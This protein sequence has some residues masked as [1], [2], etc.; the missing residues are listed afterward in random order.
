MSPPLRDALETQ[1]LELLPTIDKLAGQWARRRRLAADEQEEFVAT[2]RARFVENDYRALAEF[3]GGSSITTYLTVVIGRWLQDQQVA[4]DG[5]WRPSA[6]AMRL[7]V[8]AVLLERLTSRQ[9]WT[10]EEA[11]AHVLQRDG[12]LHDERSLRAIARSLPRREPM[13]PRAVEV[14][15]SHEPQLEDSDTPEL[16]VIEAESA[17]ERAE[18]EASLTQAMAS[19]SSEDQLLVALRYYD[20]H[21]VAD[22]ATRM[23]LSPKVLYRRFEQCVRKL[24]AQMTGVATSGTTPVATSRKTKGVR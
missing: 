8:E 7:G 18:A 6:A 4:R 5:R 11:I 1:F 17:A 19:L 10:M 12:L 21:S 15:G 20:G 9:G 22:I 14:D 13:R 3:R 2:V 24:R 23:G 16:H